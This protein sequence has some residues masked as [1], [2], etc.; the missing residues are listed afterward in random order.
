M[1][2]LI[3]E[4]KINELKK[5]FSE[6]FNTLV[7]ES[8]IGFPIDA[9]EKASINVRGLLETM[10]NTVYFCDADNNFHEVTKENVETILKEIIEAQQSLY[11]IKWNLRNQIQEESDV[12]NLQEL[13]INL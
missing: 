2:E 13:N 7:I 9:N 3:R 5:K 1:L 6:R 8:S 11:Q 12:I 10:E 4:N